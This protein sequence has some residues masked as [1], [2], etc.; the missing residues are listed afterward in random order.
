MARYHFK[1]L[2]IKDEYEVARLH[3]DPAFRSRIDDLFEGDF[4]LNF[5]LAPP[6]LARTDPNTGQPRKRAYGPWMLR[7]FGLLAKLR[8]LRGTA[9]D[10][11]GRTGER[12]MER[13]LLADYEADVALI[14]SH[15]DRETLT[16]AVALASLPEQIRGFG[17]VKAGN[18]AKVAPQREALRAVLGDTARQ[19]RAA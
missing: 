13:Q 6:L 17:H 12:R 10:I 8:F 5:H 19:A 7:A 15:L 1:L 4:R 3:A 16:D 18:V 2:A 9:L 11:F 14:I